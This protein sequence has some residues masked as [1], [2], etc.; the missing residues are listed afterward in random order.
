MYLNI[1]FQVVLWTL[2]IDNTQGL[3][4]AIFRL[5]LVDVWVGLKWPTFFET[6]VSQS[7][8]R[9][10]FEQKSVFLAKCFE[11]GTRL[12]IY[13]Y[14]VILTLF[15]PVTK[16]KPE[17]VGLKGPTSHPSPV[18]KS[19]ILFLSTGP[20]KTHVTLL[21]NRAEGDELFMNRRL[22]ALCTRPTMS[23]CTLWPLH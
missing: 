20:T 21:S 5:T 7:V 6:L 23:H 10:K 11:M 18:V 1:H 16:P 3:L 22:A 9:E 14:K 2:Y 13:P 4:C 8:W 12:I 15:R 19:F 17:N